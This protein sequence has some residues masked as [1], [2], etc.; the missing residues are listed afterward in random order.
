VDGRNLPIKFGVTLEALLELLGDPQVGTDVVVQ[1]FTTAPVDQ[2]ATVPSGDAA[3]RVNGS[4]VQIP[5]GGT[6]FTLLILEQPLTETGE[7]SSSYG[8]PNSGG[9][10]LFETLPDGVTFF[11]GE[12]PA[13]LAGVCPDAN[14]TENYSLAKEDD[15]VTT[16]PE[17]S[18]VDVVNCG[19][20]ISGLPGQL[21]RGLARLFLPT[22]LYARD[23]GETGTVAAFSTLFWAVPLTVQQNPAVAAPTAP[24][25]VGQL[26]PLSF[27]TVHSHDDTDPQD[28][29]QLT[30]AAT[31]GTLSAAS[32]TTTGGGIAN[33]GW[34]LPAVPGNYQVTATIAGTG[35]PA[36]TIN[37]SVTAVVT[38]VTSLVSGSPLYLIGSGN[39]PLT[40]TVSPAPPSGTVQFFDGTTPIG[41]AAVVAGVATLNL[42]TVSYAVHTFS[43]QFGGVTSHSGSTS[44]AITQHVA[45]RFTALT[46]FQAA[47]AGAVINETQDFTAFAIG[48]PITAINGALSVIP[49][50]GSMQVFGADKVLFGFDGTTRA[51]GNGAYSLSFT[52]PRNALAFDLVAQDPATG[53]ATI[54]FATAA[55]SASFNVLNTLTELDPVFIGI[56]ATQALTSL[57]VDEGTEVGGAGSEE[58]S[59]DN[60]IIANTLITIS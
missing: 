26:L 34:T 13:G 52:A 22:P 60:F 50:F 3:F 39:L 48:D 53:P 23:E 16:F 9:C 24:F 4:N 35:T 44:P 2:T 19:E 42:S 25:T 59:L 56:I 47:T 10:Y 43:A 12:N 29:V 21:L 38:T 54:S 57:L 36:M 37:L 28:G 49:T 58:V 5:G 45:Q 46:A 15:G 30:F 33:V 8:G 41:T 7:C 27:Q 32:A 40:A 6:E 31:G 55:G 11:D 17:P 1:T 20:V 51:A 18:V 14:T